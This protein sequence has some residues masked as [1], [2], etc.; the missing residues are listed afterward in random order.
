[1]IILDRIELRGGFPQ[2]TDY[3]RNTIC[4][5]YF[6][7]FIAIEIISQTFYQILQNIIARL[8]FQLSGKFLKT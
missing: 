8:Q 4:Q 1:M 2:S 3:C 7:Y 5:K 6:Q